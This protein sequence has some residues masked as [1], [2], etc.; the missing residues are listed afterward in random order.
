[1]TLQVFASVAKAFQKLPRLVSFSK[2]QD[3]SFTF[4]DI[5]SRPV[6]FMGIKINFI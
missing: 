1:M 3:S 6:S 2:L 4:R 5:I